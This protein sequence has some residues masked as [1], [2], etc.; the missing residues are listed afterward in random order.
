MQQLLTWV[1]WSSLTPPM[2]APSASRAWGAIA[3]AAILAAVLIRAFVIRR[4]PQM[5]VARAWVRVARILAVNGVLFLVLLFFRS[6]G[7]PFF[8]ARFWLLLLGI[9]DVAWVA[10][11]IR[12]VLVRIPA[13]RR[14]WEAGQQKQKYL[15]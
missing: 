13:Q 4:C 3:V 8:G 10:A 9:G 11:I 2:L 7:V 14:A 12:H 6:E 5:F 1:Y 15:R